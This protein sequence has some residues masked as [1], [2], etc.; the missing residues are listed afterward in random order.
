MLCSSSDLDME[1]LVRGGTNHFVPPRTW[2]SKKFYLEEDRS[3]LFLLEFRTCKNLI[4]KTKQTVRQADK[5]PRAR[6]KPQYFA[7]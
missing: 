1:N 2:T 3:A 5:S 6:A 4:K 7:A